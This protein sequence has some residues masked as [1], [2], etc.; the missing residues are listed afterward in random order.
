[1]EECL[2]SL[3]VF[4]FSPSPSQYPLSASKMNDWDFPCGPVVKTSP[5][6][7][8]VGGSVPGWGTKIPRP[9]GPEKLKGEAEAIL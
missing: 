9:S 5:S 7:Q 6:A 2:F 3:V 8:G 4:F 1:M